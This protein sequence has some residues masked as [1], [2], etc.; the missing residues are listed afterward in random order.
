MRP[1]VAIFLYLTAVLL[2]GAL[3]APWAWAFVQWSASHFAALKPLAE[4]PFHR[5][6]NRCFL[7]VA[8]LGLRPFLRSI[9][10][11]SFKAVGL[12]KSRETL[13]RAG[14]GV[15][16]G[17]LSLGGLGI[18]TLLGGARE[19]QLNPTAVEWLVHFVNATLS[20]AFVGL[21]E[22]LFFRGAIFGALRRSQNWP[23]ALI[24]SSLLYALLHFFQRTEWT[25]PV[26]WSAGLALLPGMMHGFTAV[27]ELVPA[28]FNLVLVGAILALAYQRTGSLWFSIGLHAGWVWCLKTFAFA[29]H[30]KE[31]ATQW[32]WGTGKMV[33]GWLAL[34]VLA[35]VLVFVWKT[36]AG[37]QSAGPRPPSSSAS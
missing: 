5:Y 22:E 10:A 17:L 25:G 29:T 30:A 34:G 8:M 18:V 14:Q 35:A 24:L 1:L 12:S 36:D 19:L 27:N 23:V 11:N 6:V 20:A 37:K 16:L 13:R 26:N 31:G 7:V 15:A 4:M 33:D 3:L 28:F 9:G 2:G 21:F 32:F